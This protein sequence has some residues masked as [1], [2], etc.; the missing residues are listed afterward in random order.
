[1]AKNTKAAAT[2]NG[3][4][5]TTTNG[6][7]SGAKKTV[8]PVTRKQFREKARAVVLMVDG[9]PMSV[10]VKEFSTGSFGWFGSDKVT[11]MIDGVPVKVQANV[12]LTVVN[13]KEAAAE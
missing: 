1:M 8:C 7:G 10:E 3:G 5:T 6:N 12:N 4:T 2:G 9:V 13:S 11:V